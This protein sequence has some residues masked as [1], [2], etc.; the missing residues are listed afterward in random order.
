MRTRPK[1]GA[2]Q[3]D[4]YAQGKQMLK[5][6][7]PKLDSKQLNTSAA[8]MTKLMK[9]INASA[10]TPE[11]S[12]LKK[13]IILEAFQKSLPP[14][15]QSQLQ[16]MK[17]NFTKKTETILQEKNLT[18]DQPILDPNTR[19]LIEQE[20]AEA[21]IESLKEGKNHQQEICKKCRI[22]NHSINENGMEVTLK[23]CARCLEKN[24]NIFYC[25]KECQVADWPRHRQVE[26]VSSK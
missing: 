10:A 18:F 23:K 1:K 24:P 3:I 16:D 19:K 14:D 8:A 11:E 22:A 13:K 9:E 6:L 15:V 17:D 12:K 21:A 7:N 4:Y 5:A 20:M 2:P 26:C 25:S